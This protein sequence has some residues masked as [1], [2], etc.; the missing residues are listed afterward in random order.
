MVASAERPLKMM[1]IHD[2]LQGGFHVALVPA[3]LSTDQV[4][5]AFDELGIDGDS[6]LELDGW[7]TAECGVTVVHVPP[8]SSN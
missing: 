1:V 6:V 8:P 5:A 7:K 4:E 3:E 2:R